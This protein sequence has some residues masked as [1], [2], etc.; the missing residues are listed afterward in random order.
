MFIKIF[1]GDYNK[2]QKDIDTWADVYK[3]QI[4]DFKQSML[5]VEHNVLILITILYETTGGSKKVQYKIEK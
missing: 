5:A 4:V 1:Q 2:V 3:P